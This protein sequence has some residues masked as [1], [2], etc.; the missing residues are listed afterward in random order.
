MYFDK[1][2]N[3]KL[4]NAANEEIAERCT[5]YLTDPKQ[6][7]LFQRH[8]RITKEALELAEELRAFNNTLFLS[9]ILFDRNLQKNT[10]TNYGN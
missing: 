2:G 7:E 10:Y 5:T 1:K 8:E 3:A 4:K 9:D 6:I